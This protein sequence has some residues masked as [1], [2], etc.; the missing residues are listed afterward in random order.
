VDTQGGHWSMRR[1]FVDARRSMS[2]R[3]WR[4]LLATSTQGLWTNLFG[5]TAEL[6]AF[7]MWKSTQL[8]VAIVPEASRRGANPGIVVSL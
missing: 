3:S 5:A 8:Q 6:L 2:F 4:S 7:S 1:V